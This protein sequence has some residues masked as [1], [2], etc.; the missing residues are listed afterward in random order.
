MP[1]ALSSD[2][3]RAFAGDTG[4]NGAG[5]SVGEAGGLVRSVCLRCPVDGCP[6]DVS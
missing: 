2:A 1:K 3:H 5:P 6:D 4:A